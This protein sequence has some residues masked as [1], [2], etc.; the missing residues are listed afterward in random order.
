MTFIQ[1]IDLF[2][3]YGIDVAVL[4]LATAVLTQVLK[5]TVFKKVQKKILT[6]I[7]FTIGTL[8]YAVYAA[9]RNLSVE[10]LL[11][12][13]AEILEHGLAIG[14][15][16]TLLYVLYEQFI[17]KKNGLSE[18]EQVV[19]ALIEG[20][21]PADSV[22]KVAKEVSEAILKDVTGNGAKLCEEII[23]AS[24]TEEIN[25]RDIQLLSKLIIET[26][27]HISTR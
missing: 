10:Y 25:E 24:A 22:E 7:P 1:I 27:A 19:S 15:L 6:F 20:Y 4:A 16:A 21:V 13:Y 2:T 12:N 11:E 26:L 3:F 18:T 8:L 14:S 23:A 9:V 17:R 5:I